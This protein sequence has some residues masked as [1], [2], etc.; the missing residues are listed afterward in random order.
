MFLGYN[1]FIDN[2]R[3]ITM[4]DKN[5]IGDHISDHIK[6]ILEAGKK[7]PEVLKVLKE[8]QDANKVLAAKE[9]LSPDEL[10]SQLL[11]QIESMTVVSEILKKGP[12]KPEAR[13]KSNSV[14]DSLP[15]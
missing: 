2:L 1:G 14:G 11:N 6:Q 13:G 8:N 10:Q 4:A 5:G 7:N 3:R 12:V 9:T 15:D